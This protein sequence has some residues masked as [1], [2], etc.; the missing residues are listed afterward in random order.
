MVERPLIYWF[1]MNFKGKCS[2]F[3]IINYW[4]YNLNIATLL[5]HAFLVELAS[6]LKKSRETLLISWSLSVFGPFSIIDSS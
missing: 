6:V 1:L 3:L 5:N 4:I 2:Q